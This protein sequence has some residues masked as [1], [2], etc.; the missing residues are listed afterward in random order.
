MKRIPIFL[1]LAFAFA[2]VAFAQGA[3]S[4]ASATVTFYCPDGE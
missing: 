3:V 1:I 2:G 4:D